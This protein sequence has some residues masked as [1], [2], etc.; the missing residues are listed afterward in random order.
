MT[1]IDNFDQHALYAHEEAEDRRSL[2]ISLIAACALHIAFLFITIPAFQQSQARP[3]DE[4][5][6]VKLSPAPRFRAEPPP[7]VEPPKRRQKVRQIPVPDPD[8]ENDVFVAEIE[9]DIDLPFDDEPVLGL[10]DAPPTPEPVVDPGPIRVGGRVAPPVRTHYVDPVYPPMA[11]RTRIQGTVTLEA[12]I[13]TKGHVVDLTVVKGQPMGL[14]QAAV[15][16][17]SQW[18]FQPSKVGDTLV[19]VLYRVEV[20]FTLH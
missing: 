15:D 19:P 6:V 17:V 14:S 10:P 13:D 8:P 4:P 3:A 16:A 5:K 9:P 12:T 11:R 20:A 7:V 1:P 2:R 18:R